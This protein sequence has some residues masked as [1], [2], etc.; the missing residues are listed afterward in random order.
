VFPNRF[1][2]QMQFGGVTAANSDSFCSNVRIRTAKSLRA[3][4]H[5]R[6]AASSTIVD[7]TGSARLSARRGVR[8]T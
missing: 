8:L 7:G 4:S 2:I 3:E 1:A 5:M 6:A